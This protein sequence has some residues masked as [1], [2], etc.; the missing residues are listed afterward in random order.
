MLSVHL[1]T[2]HKK[3]HIIISEKTLPRVTSQIVELEAL[4]PPFF[5]EHID[6]TTIY[7][8]ISLVRNPETSCKTAGECKTSHVEVDGKNRDTP[9]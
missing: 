6:S 2:S 4:D 7:G 5:L 8:Q 3:I 9:P 1:L